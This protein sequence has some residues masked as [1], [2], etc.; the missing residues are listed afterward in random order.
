MVPV[1]THSLHSIFSI[2][3]NAFIQSKFPKS[4]NILE[5][6]KVY[7]MSLKE[8]IFILSKEVT[9]KDWAFSVVG[10]REE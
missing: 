7:S 3:N 9:S 1:S 10:E 4:E 6:L 2:R 5:I 8:F